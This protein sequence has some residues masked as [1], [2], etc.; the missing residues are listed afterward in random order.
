MKIEPIM[1]VMKLTTFIITAFFLQVSANSVA[2]HITIENKRITLKQFFNQI[3]QQTGYNV[4]WQSGKLNDQKL[5][6]VNFKNERLTHALDEV[7]P[8][9]NLAYSIAE[10]TIVIKERADPP[11]VAVAIQQQVNGLV[12]DSTNTPLSG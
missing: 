5:V 9:Q 1:R 10:K 4:L 7:L 2:Q 6:N 8:D 12:V 11:V 3:R